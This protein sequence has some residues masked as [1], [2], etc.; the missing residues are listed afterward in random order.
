MA[1]A[2]ESTY[3]ETGASTLLP[4]FVHGS[5]PSRRLQ[6]TLR[7]NTELSHHYRSGYA[8]DS[9]RPRYPWREQA[10]CQGG[11][12][13]CAVPGVA[14]FGTLPHLVLRTILIHPGSQLAHAMG[15]VD[16]HSHGRSLTD[17]GERVRYFDGGFAATGE[18]EKNHGQKEEGECW[19]RF[20]HRSILA[21]LP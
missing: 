12:E 15:I 16:A 8:R 1:I 11:S 4:P 13:W 17:S 10:D 7:R 2:L 14:M 5:F 21:R 6:Q 18:K 9:A 19:R 3:A 20:P